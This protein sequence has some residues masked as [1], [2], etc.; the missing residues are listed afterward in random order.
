[1][2][3]AG[4]ID[5]GSPSLTCYGYQSGL[6]NTGIGNA[7]TKPATTTPAQGVTPTQSDQTN[8]GAVAATTSIPNTGPA[9][10]VGLFMAM[11]LL[12]AYAHRR[13]LLRK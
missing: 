10:T 5:F 6:V 7:A 9:T 3:Q 13:Y 4:K 1:M 2:Q 12:S 8:T 11:F